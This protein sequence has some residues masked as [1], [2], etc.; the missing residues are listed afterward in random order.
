MKMR[1][2]ELIK[3]VVSVLIVSVFTLNT[4]GA[5]YVLAMR[6]PITAGNIT[7]ARFAEDVGAE[8]NR[9]SPDSPEGKT[10]ATIEN[11]VVRYGEDLLT[12]AIANEPDNDRQGFSV[13]LVG[14]RD[15][16]A[17]PFDEKQRSGDILADAEEEILARM[18]EN[19]LESIILGDRDAIL[20]DP[21][22]FATILL[23]MDRVRR[24]VGNAAPQVIE[25]CSSGDL[26]AKLVG[27]KSDI[28][29]GMEVRGTP[30]ILVISTS[31]KVKRT[32][33]AAH[34]VEI[35]ELD[36]V[37]EPQLVPAQ[38]APARFAEW[39]TAP[40]SWRTTLG[41]VTPRIMNVTLGGETV[42]VALR[43]DFENSGI[44][45]PI[46][47]N[48]QIAVLIQPTLTLA[49]ASVIIDGVEQEASYISNIS[50]AGEENITIVID[51]ALGDLTKRGLHQPLD[52]EDAEI[53]VL[54][55]RVAGIVGDVGRK[56]VARVERETED[57]PGINGTKKSEETTRF[58]EN[59]ATAV[60]EVAVPEDIGM[61]SREVAMSN[62]TSREPRKRIIAID[63]LADLARR[64]DR[65]YQYLVDQLDAVEHFLTYW[66]EDADRERLETLLGTDDITSARNYIY[67][68]IQILGR[69][70]RQEAIEVL[71][72]L[73]ARLKKVIVGEEPVV[74]VAM[75]SRLSVA[76]TALRAP[77]PAR[78][79]EW[80]DDERD[81]HST[82]DMRWDPVLDGHRGTDTKSRL[83][84]QETP[85]FTVSN[86]AREIIDTLAEETFRAAPEEVIAGIRSHLEAETST[87][88]AVT[89]PLDDLNETV[90]GRILDLLETR[91]YYRLGSGMNDDVEQILAAAE[92]LL[93][94]GPTRFAELEEALDEAELEH[95]GE[96]STAVV[97]DCTT[98]EA[99]VILGPFALGLPLTTAFAVLV[100]DN[101]KVNRFAE[102][103]ITAASIDGDQ[104]NIP[105][106]IQTAEERM[107][108]KAKS[109][110]VKMPGQI[111]FYTTVDRPDLLL[112]GVPVRLLQDSITAMRWITGMLDVT[113]VEAKNPEALERAADIIE[114]EIGT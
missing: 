66:R 3:K 60:A 110:G 23:N 45:I 71:E 102:F 4:A 32:F 16:T 20:A 36:V 97:L 41:A 78:F 57:Q 112:P 18:R 42:E 101:E 82:G 6:T 103:G 27:E 14:D 62:A 63:Q 33:E 58:A 80:S 93:T 84:D 25:A 98:L 91:G 109:T 22:S 13:G 68:A 64:T 79:A 70:G 38:S 87:T 11:I 92:A 39:Y 59:N 74:A 43:V 21:I 9:L 67:A 81:S 40:M 48:V 105:S 76:L 46:N 24:Q 50:D 75:R 2:R 89:T 28:K 49:I 85:I 54:S 94:G 44:I 108:A 29:A 99:E 106:A 12:L 104:R 31:E 47:E 8:S 34:K 53:D 113:G 19:G 55:S 52:I 37:H 69:S 100:D 111:A 26:C 77:A 65:D 72:K 7:Q 17:D 90:R 51:E 73:E 107:R 5:N 95:T 61:I 86:V 88:H 15:P 1:T 96:A 10:I 35:V 83:H 56:L 114:L 30:S